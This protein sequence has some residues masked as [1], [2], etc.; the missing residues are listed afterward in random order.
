MSASRRYTIASASRQT[1]ASQKA[2]L[3]AAGYMIANPRKRKG[4]Y[5]DWLSGVRRELKAVGGGWPMKDFK[6]EVRDLV[7][8]RQDVVAEVFTSA[9]QGGES[10]HDFVKGIMDALRHPK[11]NPRKRKGKER[12]SGAT[13]R[14]YELVEWSTGPAN[15]AK[16]DRM[17][18]K[19]AKQI[20]KGDFCGMKASKEVEKFVNGAAKSYNK[21]FGTGPRRSTGYGMFTVPVRKEVS[22]LVYDAALRKAYD[23]A[24][25]MVS[26]HVKR[27]SMKKK[28]NP[29]AARKRRSVAR[30]GSKAVPSYIRKTS[31]SA[32]SGDYVFTGGRG[33]KSYPIGDLYH[34]RLALIYAMSPTNR[35]SRPAVIHAVA[36]AYPQYR[37][38]AWWNREI[39][40]PKK[41][42]SLKT[43]G[44]YLKM[45]SG[46]AKRRRN[47]TG[48]M[49]G[50][51]A[52]MLPHLAEKYA[53]SKSKSKW[54][55]LVKKHGMEEARQIVRMS[56]QLKRKA[57]RLALQKTRSTPT[58]GYGRYR[59]LDER[60]D[61]HGVPGPPHGPRRKNK[62]A[63]SLSR[64]QKF[65]KKH[66]GK[67]HSVE[68]LSALYCVE[69]SGK[70]KAK[71]KA[72]KKSAPKASKRR[73]SSAKRA[74]DWN[75]FQTANA[76]RGW[77][78]TKMGQE[79]DKLKLGKGK[80]SKKWNAFQRKH[81]GKNWSNQRMSREWK[82]KK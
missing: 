56:K 16:M 20:A 70:A 2:R 60:P 30:K 53:K 72:K 26:T 54:P 32:A 47:P 35:V 36:A 64:W 42:A 51:W 31:R 29:T 5:P 45:K 34:A 7:G 14:T 33:R 25:E 4:T 28:S 11:Y 50:V 65:Q 37:W 79:W 46:V 71:T 8:C 10:P 80:S 23:E 9:W 39:K 43:W 22:F 82:K 40:K 21:A 77:S 74:K 44:Q 52:G 62:A 59:V 12:A 78:S 75:A 68:V 69:V 61:A 67:G 63:P 66:G 6:A 18:R 57:V 58:S 73:S 1:A 24:D 3:R 76:G 41:D 48:E 55:R 38:S 13:H 19:F 27:K 49:Q 15:S 17:V 81:S